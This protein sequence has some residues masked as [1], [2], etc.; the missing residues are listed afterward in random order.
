MFPWKIL[1]YIL[2][3]S[4]GV[5]EHLA[6]KHYILADN[7]IPLWLDSHTGGFHLGVIVWPPGVE[8]VPHSTQLYISSVQHGS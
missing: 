5:M 1:E 7:F 4:I 3:F 6:V 2:I 8:T